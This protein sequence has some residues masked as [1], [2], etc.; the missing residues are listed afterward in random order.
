M[1]T[2]IER[3]IAAFLFLFAASAPAVAAPASAGACDESCLLTVA[4]EFLDSLTAGDPSGAPFASAVRATENGVV[5]AP[6]A[7][8]WKTATG[9]GYRHTFVDPESGG[10]GVFGV[11]NET[12]DKQAVIG[13]RLK[14]VGRRIAESEL[15]VM[16]P[17]AHGLFDPTENEPKEAFYSFVAPELRSTRK[18]LMDIAHSY[19]VG[20]THADPSIVPFH[21][22]CNR[23]E[24]GVRTTNTVRFRGCA[25][26]H[27]YV[28][29][30]QSFRSLRFPVVDTK[31]G[32]V[33]A[34]AAFDMPAQ[35]R[36]YLVRGKPVEISPER[37]NLPR[38]LFLFELFKIEGGKIRVIEA[39]ITNMP[40]GTD[41]GWPGA[42]K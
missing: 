9:W 31:R 36:T 19:F 15:L 23:Y 24:N 14:V 17:G 11:V 37:Q 40:L 5:T 4:G 1:Q 32:L 27:R 39:K 21:P 33:L 3:A 13:A 8:I 6:G 10:I 28:A 22:D 25:E 35:T 7:G 34:A 20:I 38:T 12:G 29:Y 30:M 2:Q 42:D 26:S 18:E 41:M 16:R